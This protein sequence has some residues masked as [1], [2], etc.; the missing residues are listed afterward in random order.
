MS[1]TFKLAKKK[2]SQH[3]LRRLMVEQK[4]NSRDNNELG[5]VKRIESSFAKYEDNQLSCQLCKKKLS[6][7]VWKV[8]INSKQHKEN[9]ELAKQLKE[10]LENQTKAP[11]RVIQER[12]AAIAEQRVKGIKGILKN[13][14]TYSSNS[15]TIETSDA[16]LKPVTTIPQG[17]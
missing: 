12:V 11:T 4:K 15:A 17:M 3:E 5:S 6:P 1:A 14:S 8:H 13:S 16:N 2:V 10:K 7:S 9:L